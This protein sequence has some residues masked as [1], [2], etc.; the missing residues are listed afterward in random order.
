MTIKRLWFVLSASLLGIVLG[1]FMRARATTIIGD[2]HVGGL[3]PYLMKHMRVY[4]KNGSTAGYWLRKKITDGALVVMTGTNDALNNVPVK[5]WMNQ[6]AS[7]CSHSKRCYVVAPP[8]NK[9]NKYQPYRRALSGKKNVIYPSQQQTR[10][11]VHYFHAGYRYM[12]REILDAV[13]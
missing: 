12:A 5:T 8:A 11:G 7:I 10:D 6:T 4:Y 3:K 9:Y 2:S 1:G 13:K